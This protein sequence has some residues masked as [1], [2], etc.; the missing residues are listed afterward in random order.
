MSKNRH[1]FSVETTVVKYFNVGNNMY[2]KPQT[3]LVINNSQ[4][5]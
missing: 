4:I 5:N 1:E 3:I 2:N